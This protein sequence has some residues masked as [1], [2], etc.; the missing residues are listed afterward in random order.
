MAFKN[1]T[2]LSCLVGRI[3]KNT[4][5]VAIQSYLNHDEYE[6][7]DHVFN[8]ATGNCLDPDEHPGPV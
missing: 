4:N 1:K 7:Q 8:G 2:I 6:N 3:I 5:L